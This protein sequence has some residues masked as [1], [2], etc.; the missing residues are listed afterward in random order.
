MIT[1]LAQSIP[2][3]GTEIAYREMGHGRPLVLL[4]GGL[5][6]TSDEFAATPISYAGHME[7]L[8][9]TFRVIAPDT[10]GAGGTRHPGGAASA[11]LLCDDVAG[12]IKAMALDRPLVA[13]FSEGGLTTLLLGIRHPDL[14][15]AIVSDA[16]Y[17]TLN[18]D[19]PA[20][21]MLRSMFGN[22]DPDEVDPILVQRA[23]SQDPQMAYLLGRLQAEI[24]ERQGPAAW[25]VYLRSTMGRWSRWPGYGYADLS[26]I[27][28]PVLIMTGDRDHFC[29]VEEAVRAFRHLPA[30]ELAVLPATG[31]T[32]TP[33]KIELMKDFLQRSA[34]RPETDES[35]GGDSP[36]G[37]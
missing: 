28:V 31:H 17:D 4:H 10:R 7:Q 2:V 25:P 11:T 14:V 22:L 5:V 24:T 8:A 26:R 32:I 29:S 20:F 18:P 33:A 36:Q 1:E 37:G 12:L 30:G 21:S 9:R 34:S 27:S 35:G 6:S 19:A 3:N 15:D 13:G 23:L 16:G